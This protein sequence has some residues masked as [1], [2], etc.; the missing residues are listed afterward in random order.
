[1]RIL[2]ADDVRRA[3]TMPAAIE[4]VA[5]A[6]VQLSSGRAVVPL[7]AHLQQRAHESHTFVMPA[8]LEESGG[9]GLKVVSVFPHNAARYALPRIHALVTILDAATGRPAA[10]LEGSYLTALRTGAA[11]GAATRALARQEARVLVIIGA[12][13]QAYHQVEAVCAVRPIERVIIVNRNRERAERLAAALRER[14]IVANVEMVASAAAAVPQADVVCCATSSPTPVFDDVDL[15]P[16]T[17]INGI[18]SF[19]PRMVEVPPE[20][21]GR[22][23]VVVDQQ[24]AAWAEAGDLQHAR[25]LGLLDESQTVELGA[26]LNGRSPARTSDEQIT[27]FKSVGNAVQDIAVAQLALREAE[28]LGLGIEA[29]L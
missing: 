11:S 3:V 27:F 4:A 8:L 10:V 9:L 7:R 16:G 21:V 28:R 18:G 23:Y 2:S 6:F 5:S 14:A 1:M 12:G 22:A 29:S 13:V 25:N 20:T 24:T 17:H 15:R 26:V 19:T